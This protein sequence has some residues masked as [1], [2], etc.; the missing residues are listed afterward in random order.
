MIDEKI[1]QR[2]DLQYKAPARQ[3][4]PPLPQ[5]APRQEAGPSSLYGRVGDNVT[6]HT[7]GANKAGYFD[8]LWNWAW[9]DLGSAFLG[10]LRIF[11][12]SR[13]K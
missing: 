12:P 1:P 10:L 13:N 4:A 9:K 7:Q 6:F 8:L 2:L 3:D 5:D 11:L